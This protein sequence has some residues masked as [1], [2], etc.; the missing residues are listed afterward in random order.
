[1]KLKTRLTIAFI[2]NIIT[3]IVLGV[4]VTLLIGKYQL[5]SIDKTYGLTNSTYQ[6]LTN[7]MEVYSSLTTKIYN[8][9]EIITKESPELLQD[10][11]Y[12]EK[13]NQVLQK[14]QSYL[15]VRIANKLTY[16]G[17]KEQYAKLEKIGLPKYGIDQ[18]KSETGM[19]IGSEE[20]ALV[21][22]LDFVWGD[23]TNCSA[24]IITDVSQGIPEVEEYII[25]ILL[26]FILIL[27]ITAMSLMFWIRK[28]I[29][30][31]IERMRIATQNIKN[32]KLD[33]ELTWDI[34]DEIG[35]LCKD[36][37]EMRKRLQA[38]EEEIVAYDQAS[39]ELISN[40]THD[41]KTPITA[42]KGY[43]EGILD[44][45]A[46]TGEKQEKYIRTISNKANEL[47]TLINE[48][49]VYS[50][51]DRSRI[52]YN[53]QR[54]NVKAYFDDCAEDLFIELEAKGIVFQYINKVARDVQIIGDPEQLSRVVHN[55]ISNSVKYMDKVE[56][57]IQLRVKES[58][59]NIL[60]EIEDNG[61]GIRGQDIPY[62]FDRFYRTDASRNSM[63][64]GSGIGL[65]IVK[66]IME[67]HNGKIWAKS[68]DKV[69]TTM[70]FIIK[71]CQEDTNE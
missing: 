6:S 67:E 66:K 60:V 34:K 59:E 57:R 35:E 21:K 20:P 10:Q 7:P 53:F 11:G 48:L 18:Y 8:E 41:L 5:S 56:Q 50:K 31:P 25:S 36:F 12:I 65:S 39:K 23:A 24:F 44:G 14:K 3:P 68:I 43:A 51:F 13:V 70:C 40:I 19:Y 4:L 46:D 28:G 38:N 9:V 22:Q 42:I 27:T 69:G 32:G 26:A 47:N 71:K 29:V 33:F 58:G 30:K 61:K 45:V 62:I 17:D 64:G 1:M 2:I 37:E 49:T 16:I 55:I 52:P 63:T 54:L 15:V